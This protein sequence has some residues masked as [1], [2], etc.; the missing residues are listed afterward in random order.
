MMKK[1][2][3]SALFFTLPLSASAHDDEHNE[4]AL[5]K[6]PVILA[7]I[8]ALEDFKA[9][10]EASGKTLGSELVGFV[11]K[12]ADNDA[13]A[14][15]FNIPETNRLQDANYDCHF[16]LGEDGHAEDAHCHTLASSQTRD[17][18]AAQGSFSVGDFRKAAESAVKLFERSIGDPTR[19]EESKFWRSFQGR[20]ANIQVKLSW[21]KPDGSQAT[22]FLYCHEH[23]HGNDLEIDCHR[24]RAAGPHQP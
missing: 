9:S 4:G 10:F 23:R 1:I 3:L 24:Q 8:T 7:G 2:F 13:E 18:F 5:N 15:V 14:S 17:Y 11:S 20:E 19:I 12:Q 16:H 6:S 21:K 22:N